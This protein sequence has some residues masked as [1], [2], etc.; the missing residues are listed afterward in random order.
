MLIQSNIR[1]FYKKRIFALKCGGDRKS[2]VS[3]NVKIENQENKKKCLKTN[4]FHKK[5]IFKIDI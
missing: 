2:G 1:C 5:S 3:E 4:L